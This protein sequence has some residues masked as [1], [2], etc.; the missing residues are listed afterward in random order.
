MIGA[1]TRQASTRTGARRRGAGRC[2]SALDGAGRPAWSSGSP[3][4]GSRWPPRWRTGLRGAARRAG[5][6]EARGCPATRSWPWGRSAAA[7][8]WCATTTSSARLGV[9]E[10]AIEARDPRRDRRGRPPGAGLPR[11]PAAARR[12]PVGSWSSS[13]TGSPPGATMRAAVGRRAQR[14]HARAVVVAVPVGA[15]ETCDEL[16]RLADEVVCP[17]RPGDFRAVGLLVRGLH[18]DHRR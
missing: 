2:R 7:A 1:G 11:R 17:H 6:A 18:P 3:A 5:R 4:A 12:S 9:D 16:G 13:T 15:P 8:S 10:A 14:S